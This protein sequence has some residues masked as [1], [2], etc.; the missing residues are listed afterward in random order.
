[1]RREK[2]LVRENEK[3]EKA[4]GEKQDPLLIH[5][6]QRIASGFINGLTL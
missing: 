5:F 1:M 4:R 3:R 2:I 6:K